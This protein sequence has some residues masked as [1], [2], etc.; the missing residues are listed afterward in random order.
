MKYLLIGAVL[1]AGCGANDPGLAKKV[2]KSKEQL[3]AIEQRISDYHPV[4]HRS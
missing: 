3:N 2:G 4:V 1:L